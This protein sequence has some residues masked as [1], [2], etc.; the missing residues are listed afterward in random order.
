MKSAA[1]LRQHALDLARA[2]H[3]R[4]VEDPALRPEDA[5]A[6]VEL[7]TVICAPITDETLY[8]VALHEIGHLVDPMGALPRGSVEG[9]RASLS[10]V[11]EDAAW[12]WARHYA[13]QWTPVMEAVKTWAFGTYTA[14]VEK[15]PVVT[16]QRVN[17]SQYESLP[18]RGR[19]L[20]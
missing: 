9:D 18:P 20:W 7:R 4:V 10:V 5:V 15:P 11:Q 12:R 1:D 17:W 8:A 16:K 6:V 2:F 14:N 13:L 3:V 19:K